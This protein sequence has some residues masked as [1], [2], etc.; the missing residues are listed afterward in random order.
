MSKHGWYLNKSQML[1]ELWLRGVLVETRTCY[2]M[3]VR[4]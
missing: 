3:R 2:I 1:W 4:G